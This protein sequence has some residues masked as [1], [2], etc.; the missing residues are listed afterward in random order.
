MPY[1]KHC[2]GHLCSGTKTHDCEKKG[3]LNVDE[4]D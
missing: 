4:G 2:H 1:C 3:L